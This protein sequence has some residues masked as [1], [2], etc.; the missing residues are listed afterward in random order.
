MRQLAFNLGR[1]WKIARLALDRRTGKDNIKDER[2]DPTC[3][4]RIKIEPP[5]PGFAFL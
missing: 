2:L 5:S 3:T 4:F 1:R